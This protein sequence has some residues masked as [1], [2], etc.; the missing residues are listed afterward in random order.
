MLD[1]VLDV[2]VVRSA[3]RRKTIEARLVDGIL[4]VHVPGWMSAEEEAKAVDKM[5]RRFE[6]SAAAARIDL[7][8]RAERLA[9][10]H[11]LPRPASITWAEQQ[12]LWGTC[13]PSTGALRISS[14][15]AAWPGWVLDYVI[16]HELAHL[17]E[18]DHNDA[19]HALEA[20]YPKAERAIGFLIAQGWSWA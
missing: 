5:R 4:R 3:K 19:F 8:A 6:R 13:T 9:A 16:V 10:A 11:D 17:V 20:R 2:E 1:T 15:L 18:I 12:T 7:M 14:R